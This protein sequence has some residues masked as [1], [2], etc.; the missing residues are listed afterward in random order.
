M[1]TTTRLN[2]STLLLFLLAC[3]AAACTTQTAPAAPPTASRADIE[4]AAET[5]QVRD[6]VPRNATLEALL[7]ANG[8]AGEG[9]PQVIGAVRSVFDPRRL[10]SLQ[11][12]LLERTL[13]G[14]LR[15]FEY[16]IDADTFLRVTGAGDDSA[17]LR[18]EVL[19]IPKTVQHMTVA[20]E[21]RDGASSLYA[22]MKAAGEGDEL[23]IKLAQVF[24]G[25]IDFNSEVQLGDRFVVSFERYDRAD[26][27][28]STYGDIMAAVMYTDG[29]TL[30]A[31]RFAPP[32]GA[33]G[34]Y[35]EQGRSFRRFFLKSPLRFDPR[36][37]SRFSSRR[38]HPVLHTARAHRG[39]DYAAPV[40]APVVAVAAGTVV[41]ATYD[42]ANGRMVR[43]K[44]ASGYQTYYLHLS[45]FAAGMRAGRHVAQD[46][47]IGYVGSSGLATGPHLH[48]ALTRDGQFVDPL[49]EH[50]RMPPGE[51]IPAAAMAA[52]DA[53]RNRELA[54]LA[55]ASRDAS[56][57]VL[58]T[59]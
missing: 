52:F 57:P 51:P 33:P 59:R 39:V 12:F 28:A 9:V 10:R 26:G 35:D 46:E 32:G 24:A 45:R 29:R 48:Y 4:L 14:G 16:E 7:T 21:V 2:A 53:L 40:G 18:A 1:Q 15:V 17:G 38:M 50:R 34:Y 47:V 31:I 58:A 11:P 25:E 19:P 27:G 44:H 30:R 37:T 6:I 49:A 13:V 20:G 5:R 55:A 42:N 3:F 22:A 41:S 36:V 23:A 43:V 8:I 54:T 56:L